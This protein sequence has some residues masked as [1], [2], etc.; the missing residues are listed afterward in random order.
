MPMESALGGGLCYLGGMD[1][2]V[3]GGGGFGK[4]GAPCLCCAVSSVCSRVQHD[5][6]SSRFSGWVLT[7]TMVE[8]AT[9]GGG[10]VCSRVG[11]TA[12]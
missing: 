10:Q 2:V 1:T 5:L 3:G 11:R 12:V 9:D 6:S 4:I 8:G 7:L